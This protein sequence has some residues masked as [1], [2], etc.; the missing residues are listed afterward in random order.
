MTKASQQ[1]TPPEA[2]SAARIRALRKRLGYTQVRFGER[3]GL[4]AATIA[5]FEGGH[6]RATSYAKRAAL[7]KGAEVSVDRLAAY[8]DGQLALDGLLPATAQDEG[9]EGGA[10]A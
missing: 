6:N 9:G 5:G 4:P 3:C 1:R 8:L 7:A 2:T 10:A